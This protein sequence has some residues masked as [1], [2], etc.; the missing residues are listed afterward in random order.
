M[1]RNLS[2]NVAID[3][4]AGAGKSTAARLLAQK[5]GFLYIDTGAMYRALT[6]KALQQGVNLTEAEQLAALAAKTSITLENTAAGEI[7]VF[8]D[9][10]D[11][12]AA[13]RQEEVSRGVSA[14]AR[15]PE[16][17]RRLVAIQRHLAAINRVVMDGRDI[18]TNVLPDAPY[19]FFLTASLEERSRR[20]CQE[21]AASGQQVDLETVKAEIRRRDALDSR[22]EVDPLRP[23]P[24]AIII[25]T[26]NLTVDEVA[27]KIL[28]LIQ[29]G[30]CN[31]AGGKR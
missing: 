24:D 8:C 21:L 30:S 4:P 25:D 16:V 23:A 5:L 12:T 19:K 28:D 18:G 10:R 3:G 20:R 17:R 9:H 22:R 6:W 14:V 13:I 26:S 1:S 27:G 29:S 11:I 7:R 2:G 15:V 31:E